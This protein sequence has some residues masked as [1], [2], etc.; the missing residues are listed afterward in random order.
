MTVKERITKE[1]TSLN[2]NQ[3]K[4]LDGY[5]D[6]IKTR[7]EL[8]S[9]FEIHDEQLAKLYG[10]CSEED[11]TMAEQDMKEYSASLSKEDHK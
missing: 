1:L 4:E 8:S 11:R 5:V 3:L 7:S 2:E 9:S 10:E 6:Y